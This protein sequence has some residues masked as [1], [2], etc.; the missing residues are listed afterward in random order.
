MTKLRQISRT[1]DLF[2]F[3]DAAQAHGACEFGV[4]VGSKS[5]GA[6]FSFYPG[7]NLG[8]FG[9][10]GAICVNDI[11]IAKMCRSLRSYGSSEKY[12]H[13]VIGVN[14][15]MD[16]IQAAILS[17]KIGTI[18]DM[19]SER[20]HIA[21]LYSRYITNDV[22][23][24]P[25]VREGAKHVWHLFVIQCQTRDSLQNYLLEQGIDTLIHYPLPIFDQEAFKNIDTRGLNKHLSRKRC[26]SILSLPIF[27]HMHQEEAL[28]VIDKINKYNA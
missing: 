17:L 11:E 6:A 2:L 9:D 8:A 27:P 10:A 4:P 25:L 20:R 3:E 21:N 7:K 5:D 15:R 24:K 22:V 18:W 1:H 14:S 19:N 13:D 12:K 16:P 23:L 28:Y 26:A